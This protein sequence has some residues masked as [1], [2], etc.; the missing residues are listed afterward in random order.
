MCS[1]YRSATEHAWR[2]RERAT[3]LPAHTGVLAITRCTD[4]LGGGSDELADMLAYM[5]EAVRYFASASRRIENNQLVPP[6][7][8]GQKRRHVSR[9]GDWLQSCKLAGFE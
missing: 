9:Q 5:S 3:R 1:A 7:V 2:I 4:G 6:Y 8:L